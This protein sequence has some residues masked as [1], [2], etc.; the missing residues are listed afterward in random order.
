MSSVFTQI[1]NE[2]FPSY[3][4]YEDEVVFAIL[5]LDQIQLGH[6]LVILKREVDHF[7]D[8]SHKETQAVALAS[9]KI[10]K[11]IYE[12]TKCQRVCTFFQGYEVPHVHYHLVPTRSA[13][14]FNF[15]HQRRRTPEEMKEVCE[16]I[17]NRL[18]QNIG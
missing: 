10:A 9:Q 14:D 5:A 3:K 1:L 7:F 6:T 4:V 8:M 11:A 16:R 13:Q 17:K 2:E 18:S 12:A 15:S